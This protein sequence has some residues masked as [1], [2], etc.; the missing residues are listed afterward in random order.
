MPKTRA[1]GQNAAIAR[2]RLAA[3]GATDRGVAHVRGL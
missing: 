1:P 3:G 2:D